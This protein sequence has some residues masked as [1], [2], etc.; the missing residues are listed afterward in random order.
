MVILQLCRWKFFAADVIRL[1]L[2][3]IQKT[4]KSLFEPPFGRLKG[5]VR[6]VVFKTRY[7]TLQHD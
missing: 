1:K 6:S 2:N 7:T 3:F 5:N 4:K